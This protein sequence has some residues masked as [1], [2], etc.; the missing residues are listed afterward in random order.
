MKT[1]MGR[2]D[3]II[4]LIFAIIVGVLFWQHAIGG[5]LAYV[6]LAIA[7]IFVITSFIGFCPLYTLFGFS[8]CKIKE[9]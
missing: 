9:K 8:S 5:I 1:N 6:L 2:T 3:R 4:R 7:A